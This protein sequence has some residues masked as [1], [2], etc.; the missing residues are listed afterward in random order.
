MGG[1]LADHAEH[2]ALGDSFHG[3]HGKALRGELAQ[4]FGQR[5]VIAELRN[6]G[7]LHDGHH[8][9]PADQQHVGDS[10]GA[11]PA[12]AKAT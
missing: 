7:P 3:M 1:D 11:R 2:G 8:R 5:G 10:C 6:D 9:W 12:S 4:F